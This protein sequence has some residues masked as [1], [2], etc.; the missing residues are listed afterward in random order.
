M[1]DLNPVEKIMLDALIEVRQALGKH[2]MIAKAEYMPLMAHIRDAI[3][4]GENKKFG[5]PWGLHASICDCTRT[6]PGR[7]TNIH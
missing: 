6:T 4:R 3:V 5:C 7:N 1:I 2:V